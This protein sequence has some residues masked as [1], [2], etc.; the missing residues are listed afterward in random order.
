VNLYEKLTRLGYRCWLDI[1]QMGGGD[2]LFE[3]IDTGVR[4][5]KCILAC[6]TPKYTKSI[7][8]RREMALSDALKKPIIPLLF[9]ETST[10]PPEGPMA[11][12]FAE[13]PY[14]DFRRAND[15]SE[16]WTGKEFE[17]V[18]ARLQQIIPEVQ[19]EK[20]QRYLIDMQRPTTATKEQNKKSKRIRSAPVTPL[21]RACSIM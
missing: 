12:V 5:A 1:F 6:V 9:E 8:C 7:N 19:T 14:I 20:P 21:S 16:R 10:W 17:S 3:K 4:H 2:S 18:L 13:K 11:M 15:H